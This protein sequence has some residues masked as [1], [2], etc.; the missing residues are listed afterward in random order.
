VSNITLGDARIIVP[1]RNGGERWCEAASALHRAIP[2]SGIVAVVDS[3]STDG[4]DRV[5]ADLGFDLERIDPRKFNH[6]RT[7][8][9]AVDSFCQGKQFVIFLTQDAVIEGP[10][11][12]T[13]LLAAFSQPKVGAAYGRQLPHRNAR[14]FARHS[15]LYLY[16]PAG[17][18]RTRAD[19]ARLGIRAAY[20]SNSFAAYRLR[21][22]YECGGFPSSLIL[23]E[24]TYLSLNMLMGG[25]A[26]SY[27]ADALVRHSHDYT[28]TE[29]ARR[30]FDFGV[31]HAQLPELLREFGQPEA[32]GV[33]FLKSETRYMASNA[34]WCLPEVVLRNTAKY[35][36]YR[37]GRM[38]KRLPNS[39]R[40]RLSM[41][42]RFWDSEEADL[43]H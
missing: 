37:L 35:L 18:V 34:P 3:S 5:A 28:I 7:R 23:G 10:D 36:S 13:S 24:D 17:G 43:L 2:T 32:E 8:Q 39:L 15:A 42:E 20:M 21:A 30:Y 4:S 38:F 22:L 11:S 25:W 6:G 41:T 26:V 16:P 33:R 31:F 12:L 9:V 27:R 19:A 29:E 14:P 1:V 40:R